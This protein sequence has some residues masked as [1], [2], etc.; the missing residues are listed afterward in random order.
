MIQGFQVPNSREIRCS[1]CGTQVAPPAGLRRAGLF[2]FWSRG[3]ASRP[4]SPRTAAAVNRTDA[5]SF[6]AN[7]GSPKT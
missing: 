2:D 7:A 6:A 4:D 5:R 1:G 3:Q